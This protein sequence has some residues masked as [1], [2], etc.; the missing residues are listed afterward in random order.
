MMTKYHN[1]LKR[2]KEEEKIESF[3]T[4]LTLYVELLRR[5]NCKYNLSFTYG[6]KG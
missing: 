4:N 1:Q 6:E 3:K 2:T 5:I